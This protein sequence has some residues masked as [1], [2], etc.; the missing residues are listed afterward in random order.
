MKKKI[1]LLLLI[2][3]IFLT[4]ITTTYALICQLRNGNCDSGENCILSLNQLTNSH[5]G[6]CTYGIVKVC[7][8]QPGYTMTVNIRQSVCL[9]T[10]GGVI[11]LNQELNSHVENYTQTNYNYRVCLNS[12]SGSVECVN[13]IGSCNE[14][15]GETGLVSLF[16][17]VNSHVADYSDT[18]YQIK[19]CCKAPEC[20]PEDCHRFK[21]WVEPKSSMFTVGRETSINLYVQNIGFYGDDYVITA[22]SSNPPLFQVDMSG[23]SSVNDVNV[24]EIRRVYPTITVMATGVA[25]QIFFNATS[26]GNQ[27]I[28]RN[29]TLSIIESELPMSLPEFNFLGMVMIIILTGIIYYFFKQ[30]Y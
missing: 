28:T 3:T 17:Y 8:S 20:S 11:R 13:R 19:V 23:A 29:A 16:N 4:N 10:E 1:S 27:N 15:N 30:L 7:C 25:G 26:Q 24:G 5:A 6:N 12:T 2:L 18:N 21:F 14:T 22:N 9:P